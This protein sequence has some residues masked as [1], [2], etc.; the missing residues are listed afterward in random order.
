MGP[1]KSS[2]PEKARRRLDCLLAPRSIAIIG[3]SDNPNKL[4]GRVLTHLRK[5]GFGG[6]IWPVNPSRNTIGELK[7]YR[8]V[9]SLPASPDLALVALGPAH[10]VAAVEELAAAG[11][12]ACAVL[13]S[14]FAEMGVEG[15]AL[16]R[17]MGEIAAQVGMLLLGPNGL[18][19]VNSFSKTAASFS[20]FA[21]KTIETSPIAFV[22]QSGAFGTAIAGLARQ[23]G[24][25]MG[26]FVNTG[27]EAALDVWDILD[28][29][30]EDPQ[31]GIL[32]A[33]VENLGNGWKIARLARRAAAADKPLVISKVGNSERG[34]QAAAAHTGA[35][36]TPARLFS[37]VAARLGV[38]SAAD[39]RDMLNVIAAYLRAGRP[40]G[41]RLGIVTMSGGAG[42][43]MADVAEGLKA[44]LTDFSAQTVGRLREHVPAFG[45]VQ[46]PVDITAQFLAEPEILEKSVQIVQADPDVD[47]VI[48]WLQMMDSHGEKLAESLAR[49]RDASDTPLLVAW[50]AASPGTT[51][52]LNSQNLAAFDNGGD[53]VRSAVALA[54]R[55]EALETFDERSPLTRIPKRPAAP[56]ILLTSRAADV[57]EGCGV[58]LV[59]ETLVGSAE[60]AAAAVTEG[61]N[62]AMKIAS[63]EIPHRSDIGG[64][65]L[66][67]DRPEAAR[68]AH[69]AL[70]DRASRHAPDAN[71]EGV[72][73]QHMVPEGVEL[74]FG[75]RN[76]DTFGPVVMIG[77]G[78]VFVEMLGGVEFALA[79]V[80][81]SQARSMIDALPA[82][83]VLDGARGR[84]HVDRT[85][86]A[87]GFV[88]F[89]EFFAGVADAIDEIDLNPVI[90]N[91]KTLLAVDWLVSAAD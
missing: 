6:A 80:S 15:A 91:G 59:G 42:V 61:F 68:E 66:N 69:T 18:G 28:A 44:P 89:S 17:R 79:P 71:I 26:W 87:L 72:T 3:A 45:S 57:L 52:A 88:A 20:Q 65:I 7:C 70:I 51:A 85:E 90:A 30:V 54:G 47:C 76:D 56:R 62:Y 9:S 74:V 34:A 58:A 13:A 19:F 35:L 67:V 39:E 27:N 10:S 82:Q 2:Q 1:E 38:I 16:E 63:P 75:A 24:L 55:T 23:R 49:C 4:S 37:G 77:Y 32:A 86:L 60:E 11:A 36:A 40:K 8:D 22:S 12:G 84:P 78:G 43:L 41:R 73:V 14:G 81:K 21:E 48:V 53:A 25:G 83:E 5:H 46:N 31:I 29:A 64:V 50:I 33:Y